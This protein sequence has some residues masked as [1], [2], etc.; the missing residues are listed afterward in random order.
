MNPVKAVNEAVLKEILKEELKAQYRI[1]KQANPTTSEA[2]TRLIKYLI[3]NRETFN[4]L[5]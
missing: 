3:S 4:C 5:N 2:M 1:L